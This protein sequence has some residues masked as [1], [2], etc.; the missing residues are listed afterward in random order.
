MDE[1]D[2]LKR[3]RAA[4]QASLALC[5][6]VAPGGAYAESV[7][8]SGPLAGCYLMRGTL[9]SRMDDPVLLQREPMRHLAG[10]KQDGSSVGR[11]SATSVQ[12]REGARAYGKFQRELA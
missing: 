5:L 7:I 11:N 10:F 4:L 8:D 1:D 6:F 3:C 9:N 12:A 2:V